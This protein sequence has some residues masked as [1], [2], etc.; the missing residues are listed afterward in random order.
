MF[1]SNSGTSGNYQGDSYQ[2]IFGDLVVVQAGY[3]LNWL[4]FCN[5]VGH[6]AFVWFTLVEVFLVMYMRDSA[7][8]MI[9]TLLH[10][11]SIA[12]WQSQGVEIAK[13]RQEKNLSIVWPLN[14]FLTK[15]PKFM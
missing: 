8:L 13:Y 15:H 2:N 4:F 14:A 12:K 3:M 11:K 6:L 10:I 7:I 5:G 1:R 9:N